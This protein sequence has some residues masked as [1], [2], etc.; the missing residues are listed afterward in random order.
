MKR[1]I[2]NYDLTIKASVWKWCMLFPFIFHWSEQVIWPPLEFREWEFII[3][4][5]GG[6]HMGMVTN[7]S[8]QWFP[9]SPSHSREVTQD[10][11]DYNNELKL[12]IS[13]R[14][15]IVPVLGLNI[16]PL[17]LVTCKLHT[18]YMPHTLPIPPHI[19]T[20]GAGAASPCGTLPTENW[21]RKE[22]HSISG[23]QQSPN[24]WK[25]CCHF[26]YFVDEECPLYK[27]SF[28]FL[29]AAPQPIVLCGYW[30]LSS[31]FL[32]LFNYF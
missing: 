20:V 21:Y 29:G 16:V 17:K 12:Q 6:Y 24:P 15:Q 27:T 7:M 5:W 4:L 3:C 8:E 28:S 9:T 1:E 32:F 2:L 22:G 25:T 23:L 19:R 10:S 11:Y 26:F 13:E 30:L 14:C 31:F 18:N